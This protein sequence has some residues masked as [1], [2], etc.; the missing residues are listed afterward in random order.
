MFVFVNWNVLSLC[1]NREMRFPHVIYSNLFADTIARA[2]RDN[3]SFLSARKYS[4]S[5]ERVA[6]D[7]DPSMIMGEMDNI[8]KSGNSH[9][10]LYTVMYIWTRWRSVSMS[11][12]MMNFQLPHIYTREFIFIRIYHVFRGV[13]LRTKNLIILFA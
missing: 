6:D 9:Y 12:E 11:G 1:A 8:F 4:V 13:Y 7:F 2:R 5:S 10:A 3:T